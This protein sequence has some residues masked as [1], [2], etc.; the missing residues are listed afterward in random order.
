MQM[1]LFLPWHSPE[2]Q[3]HLK[4]DDKDGRHQYF[5]RS[6]RP[7]L[8]SLRT[9]AGARRVAVP[10]FTMQRTAGGVLS[11]MDQPERFS[12][13]TSKRKLARAQA[14]YCATGCKRRMALPRVAASSCSEAHG[15]PGR[16][17]HATVT[18]ATSCAR[19]ALASSVCQTSWN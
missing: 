8:H 19:V 18:A 15:D 4:A 11:G 5:D 16:R 1:R 7:A 6:A 14:V 2:L 17:Q 12:R 10:L 9:G 3:L 13:T